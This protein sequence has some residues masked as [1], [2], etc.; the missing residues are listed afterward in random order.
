LRL[1]LGLGLG[2]GVGLGLWFR[3]GFGCWVEIVV[4]FMVRLGQLT[5]NLKTLGM[6]DPGHGGHWNGRQTQPLTL[7]LTKNLGFFYY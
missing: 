7:T 6:A 2:L 4:G 3:V 1:G 5:V